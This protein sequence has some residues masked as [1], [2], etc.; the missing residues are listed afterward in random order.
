MSTRERVLIVIILIIS[1]LVLCYILFLQRDRPEK[2]TSINIP[3]RI[4]VVNLTKGDSVTAY[5]QIINTGSNILKISNIDLDCNCTGY[6]LDH[7]LIMPGDS[8]QLS[9]TVTHSGVGFTRSVIIH[10]NSAESPIGLKVVGVSKA[11][12]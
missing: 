2:F 4:S 9:V 3:S 12:L 5:F 11:S 7:H 10:C 8:G 1:V 6:Y